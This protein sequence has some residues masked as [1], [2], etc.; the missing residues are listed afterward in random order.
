MYA[1]LADLLTLSRVAAA[2]LLLWLGPAHGADAL[3]V[4]VGITVLAWT[5]DQLDGWAARRSATPT[6]LGPYDFPIDAAFY[7]GILGYLVTADYLPVVIAVVFLAVAMVA[8]FSTRRKAVGILCLRLIDLFA[9]GVI[10]SEQPLLGFL[11][12][13]W[14]LILAVLYRQR[15]SE[16]VPRWFSD[17]RSLGRGR[18]RPLP[19]ETGPAERL[20]NQGG[21]L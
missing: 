21:R 20:D 14:L 17:I 18:P 6:K 15:L 16:R 1:L 7:L 13:G 9:A 5:T 2:G 10:F 19:E 11:V 3:P 8:W 12:L 4:A